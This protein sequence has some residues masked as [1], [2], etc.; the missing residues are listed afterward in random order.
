MAR[1]V[2]RVIMGAAAFC[3]AVGP[4]VAASGGRYAIRAA[5]YV[6]GHE[7]TL[8]DVTL[9][10]EEGR[11]A[12]IGRDVELPDGCLVLDR[13]AALLCPGF[14]DVHVSLG[15]MQETGEAANAIEEGADAADLFNRFHHDF[16][17]AARA[18]V[19]TVVIAPSSA[20]LVGGSTVVVKTAGDDTAQR[21]LG[22]GPLKLSLTAEAFTLDRPPT[23]LQGGLEILRRMIAEARENRRDDS[24]FAQWARGR[25][26]ALVDIDSAEGLSDLARFARSQGVECVALHAKYAAERME[27][28]RSLDQPAV[29][30]PYGFGDTLRFT[31][32]PRL[33]K[34][35]GVAFA[36]TSEAPINGPEMLRVGAAIAIRQGLGGQE[37]LVAL[38][39]TPARIAGVEARVGS[40]APG[41]DADFI[42]FSGPPLSLSSRILEVFVDGERVYRSD[43]RKA[44]GGDRAMTRAGAK[45]TEP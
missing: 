6:D 19:T 8:K 18:G 37:A 30:G 39:M 24:A 32:A 3:A 33:L 22:R 34:K 31:R 43:D 35:T 25:T 10:V 21:I 38:T 41:K 14:V 40:L 1:S 20:H 12:A 29:L 13:P 11:I 42:V 17:R 2:V 26:W 28:L 9:L 44:L 45:E 23:S 5:G 7:A 15:A 36:L 16:D 27:E 4:V